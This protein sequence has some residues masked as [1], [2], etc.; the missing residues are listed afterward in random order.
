[1]DTPDTHLTKPQHRAEAER[2]IASTRPW[3]AKMFTDENKLYGRTPLIMS[4]E[5]DYTLRLAQI[6]AT[7][8]GMD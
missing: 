4:V 2:L 3:A 8:A 1:M 6:H 5:I 7:L